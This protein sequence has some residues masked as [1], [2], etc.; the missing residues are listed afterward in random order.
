VVDQS[1]CIGCQPT[2]GHPNM[3]VHLGHLLYA[4]GLLQ[5]ACANG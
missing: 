5:V 2:H 4:A 1:A 3:L